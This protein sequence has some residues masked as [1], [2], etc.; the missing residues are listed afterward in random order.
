MALI[1]QAVGGAMA[2]SATQ[3]NQDPTK[4]GH[5]MLGGIVFQMGVYYLHHTYVTHTSWFDASRLDHL[6]YIH[7]RISDALQHG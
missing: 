6:C 5:I 7:F 2:A 4:G 1:V 3:N